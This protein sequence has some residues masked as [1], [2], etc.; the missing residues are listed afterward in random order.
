MKNKELQLIE[1]LKKYC[2]FDFIEKEINS[3]YCGGEQQHEK[4]F[5]IHIRP[6]NKNQVLYNN[7]VIYPKTQTEYD[8]L[9]KVLL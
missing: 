1:T 9:K 3:T 2:E 7:L 4:V 8:L 6:E 5:E